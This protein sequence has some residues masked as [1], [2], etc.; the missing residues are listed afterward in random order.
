[1]NEHDYDMLAGIIH[2][3]LISARICRWDNET[4]IEALVFTLVETFN[5]VDT[6]FKRRKFLQDCG[7][8]P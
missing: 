2:G 1:M 4:E 3:E 7:V 8:Q 5:K 6:N